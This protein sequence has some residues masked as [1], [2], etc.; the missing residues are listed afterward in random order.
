MNY[1][2][3]NKKYESFIKVPCTNIKGNI[4]TYCRLYGLLNEQ[5]YLIAQAATPVDD[6]EQL[7][8]DWCTESPYPHYDDI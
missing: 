5:Y 1:K 3:L 4:R 7:E 8:P 6:W 2:K